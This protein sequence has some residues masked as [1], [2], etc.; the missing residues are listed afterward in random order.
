MSACNGCD[1]GGKERHKHEYIKEVTQPTC[2][3]KG[4]STY[5]CGCGKSY[6]TDYTDPLGHNFDGKVCLRCGYESH[7]HVYIKTAVEPDCTN[8][9]YT[10][11][12]CD[13]CG[14]T[15]T[16]N[17]DALGHDIENG[18]CR[19]CGLFDAD[20][21]KHEY[22]QSTTEPD[23]T[24]EGYTTFA[25]WCGDSYKSNYTDPVHNF[26][27]GKCRRCGLFDADKHEHEYEQGTTEPDCINEG[28]TTFACW[29]GDSYK[30]EYTDPLGHDYEDGVC[31]RC[32]ALEPVNGYTLSDDGEY[33]ICTG[34]DLPSKRE[35]V[36]ASEINGKPVK[37]IAESAFSEERQLISITIPDS[38]TAIGSHAF[39]RCEWLTSITIPES[40]AVMGSCVFS[41]CEGLTIYCEAESKPSGWHPEWNDG[42][43]VVWDCKNNNIADDGSIYIEEDGIRY[44]LK[45]G[46][47]TVLK[48]SKSIVSGTSREIVLP[49]SVT[50]QGVDY[51]LTAI[52][53]SAFE[54]FYR[55]TDITI[56]YGVTA[57]GQNAFK[58]CLSL[59]KAEVPDSVRYIG[60][61]AFAYCR[62]LTA[63]HIPDGIVEISEGV[64]SQ[65]AS[66]T[67]ITIPDSVTKIDK[68][69]F[70]GCKG[71]TSV[72][73]SDS[74]AVIGDSA[75]RSC[76]NLL[77][78]TIGDGVKE[79]VDSFK[80]CFRLTDIYYN[81]TKEEWDAIAKNESWDGSLPGY[82]IHCT[83]ED[84]VVNKE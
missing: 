10:R 40:V 83:D 58:N 56:P 35:I 32:K 23:C 80:Y 47:A 8:G 30:S 77:S 34:K 46:S 3:V 51:K 67:N 42:R 17:K 50:Y 26:E 70:H 41:F 54:Y 76:E 16:V 28:Y 21:H 27:N 78:I 39:T 82:T 52:G 74:V 7:D 65:C 15:Y 25:C 61:Y 81:G 4:F 44:S 45:N 48:Q 43:A 2:T 71:L 9:G 64:Y 53:D 13:I 36:I 69:A 20:R 60:N 75:F 63:I 57:I 12:V 79:I 49:Q 33:Y 66:V 14:A 31:T 22:E 84:I 59:T 18:K 62:K 68:T 1:K 19:R 73:I 38:I 5:N 37:E 55:L 72:T 29:C 24:S 11:G 6:V